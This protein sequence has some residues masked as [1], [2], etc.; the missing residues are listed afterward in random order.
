MGLQIADFESN[1]LI[2]SFSISQIMGREFVLT[3]GLVVPAL[4]RQYINIRYGIQDIKRNIFT[5]W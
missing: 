1:L 5:R 2:K 4:I 3:Y